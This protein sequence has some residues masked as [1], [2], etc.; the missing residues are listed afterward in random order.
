MKKIFITTLLA[1]S[2]SA[3]ANTQTVLNFDE[4]DAV[5]SNGKTVLVEDI[6]DGFDSI[7]GIQVNDSTVTISNNSKAVVLFR[8]SNKFLPEV[9][10]AKLSGGD[11]GGG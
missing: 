1:L 11:G 10:G 5:I 8:N 6:R 7:K 2:T 9:L 4:V 3:F